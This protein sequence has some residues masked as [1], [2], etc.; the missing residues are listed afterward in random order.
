MATT[1]TA[2]NRS[3][4]RLQH[5]EMQPQPSVYHQETI[6]LDKPM[7]VIDNSIT[8]QDSQFARLSLLR[9]TVLKASPYAG[10][11]HLL[12]LAS[13]EAQTS[14]MALALSALSPARP[15]YA[16]VDYQQAF[17]WDQVIA[18]LS[19]LAKEQ[20]IAWKKQSFYVVE[21][22]SKLKENID[23]DR[24]YFLDKQSHMEATAS[25]GLLKYWYG[26]PDA[27][28]YNLA[29][30]KKPLEPGRFHTDRP[31]GLWRSKEDAVS[32]GSGPW[33]QQA[34]AVI[35]QMYEMIQ[36]KGL[37][38]TIEDGLSSWEFSTERHR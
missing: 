27:A 33:H 19:T 9:T 18:L 10:P 32:G 11:E 36:I 29:T 34:R 23:N 16:I 26:S 6:S 13:L 20:H 31:Q 28:R 8:V 7:S 1:I 5:D 38:L 30:C 22:R 17:H 37:S 14:L 12:Q 3:P 24:L 25:G 21:F 15:D 2:F 35:P 4:R